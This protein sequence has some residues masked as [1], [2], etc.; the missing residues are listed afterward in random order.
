MAKTPELAWEWP[1]IACTLCWR[2]RPEGFYLVKDD[3]A[4]LPQNRVMIEERSSEHIRFRF[5]SIN[6]AIRLRES[7]AAQGTKA[8]VEELQGHWHKLVVVLVWKFAKDG[9]T[10]TP[11]DWSAVPVD[12]QLRMDGYHDGIEYRFVPHADAARLMRV[13]QERGTNLIT[14]KMKS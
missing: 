9:I 1:Q 8:S 4:S 14:E 13:E 12:K 2:L 7:H 6:G 10:I 11:A 3:L 5:S